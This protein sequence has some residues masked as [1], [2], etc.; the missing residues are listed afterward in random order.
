MA[1]TQ[2]QFDDFTLDP[3]DRRLCR[4]GQT[5][6][7]SNRYFDALALL[8][9]ERGRLVTKDRF[10]GEI[11]HG[12]PVTDEALTQCIRALRRQLGDD[13]ARPR[14]IETVPKHGYR[15]IGAVEIIAGDERIAVPGI[16]GIPLP[17]RWRR[18]L[19][20][21]T[22]A[23]IGGGIAGILGGL[24]YASGVNLQGAQPALGATSI[25][26]VLLAINMVVGLAAGAGVGFGIAAAEFAAADRWQWSLLGGAVGG[27]VTG[28]AAKLVGLDA[29][30]LL[31]GQSP[32]TM[33]GAPEG[34]M[35]GAAV[36]CAA[37]LARRRSATLAQSAALGG[38]TTGAVGILIPPFGGTL[39]GGSLDLLLRQF[40]EARFRLDPIGQW[41]G[42]TGFG[43]VSQVATAGLEGLLFGACV[44]GA[45]Y[46]CSPG[47]DPVSGR[48]VS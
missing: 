25:L 36:G 24:L 39:L 6:E 29:F 38:L 5:V 8:L 4:D 35:L 34:A 42:E 41:F 48:P 15:F 33:T 27:F 20:L 18:F 7:L 31:L 3:G 2:Y 17:D 45:L 22:A 19:L 9:H 28:G 13:A 44:V 10:M 26:F 16:P 32:R 46:F 12:V 14:F 43:P 11:W 37:W 47:N 23:M 1:P 40:P 30:N 21:G